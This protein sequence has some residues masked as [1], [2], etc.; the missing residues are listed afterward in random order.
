[1][2]EYGKIR[3]NKTRIK[4]NKKNS[5]KKQMIK[6]LENLDQPMNY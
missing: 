6:Y 3:K 4:P 2:E 1:M 5:K